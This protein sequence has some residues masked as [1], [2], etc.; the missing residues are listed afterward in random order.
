MN[1][2]PVILVFTLLFLIGIIYIFYQQTI[3]KDKEKMSG[4]S[5]CN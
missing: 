2:N 5:V 4:C 1:P 3:T